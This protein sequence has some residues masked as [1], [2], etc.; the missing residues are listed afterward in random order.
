[1]ARLGAFPTP[2]QSLDQVTKSLG[3]GRV[4]V[5][6]DDVSSSTYG[7]NK[8]RTLEVLFGQAQRLGCTRIYSTGAYGS[9]HA[10]A[11][12]LHAPKVG[13]ESGVVL[14]PQ[15]RSWAALENLRVILSSRAVVRALPH[16]SALPFG[17]WAAR[18][19]ESVQGTRAFI[20]VPGGA[21]PKGA[22][23]YVSAAFELAEQ[24][25]AGEVPRPSTVVIGVGS[26]CTSAGLLVGFHHA[27]RLGIGFRDER[28]N[29]APPELVSVRVTPWP[30]TSKTMILRLASKASAELAALA[31]EPG[32]ALSPRDFA[33]HFRVDGRYLGRGYGF[34][35]SD[36]LEAQ[37]MWHEAGAHELDTTYSAKAAAAVV[38]QVRT[39]AAGPIV[40]WST[41]STTPLPPSDLDALR[42]APTRMV[43]W[44]RRAEQEL[45]AGKLELP[46]VGEARSAIRLL[47]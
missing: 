31:G 38:D 19:A 17:M 7:G 5:K 24:V 40:F 42:A 39:G 25:E 26:T 16:W 47:S 28:G 46:V 30:I 18:R 9:N 2:V 6:R 13:L 32:L 3:E 12:V 27:A 29:A 23:G 14:F 1:M 15:P 8:V 21:T 41:K 22:L 36:G 44:M 20:M 34:A 33:A 35:S 4:F 43:R 45:S 11:T 37:R 10:T